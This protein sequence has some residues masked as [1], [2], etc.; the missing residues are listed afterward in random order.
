MYVPEAQGG[1]PPGTTYCTYWVHVP[2]SGVGYVPRTVAPQALTKY[3][4]NNFDPSSPEGLLSDWLAFWKVW[5]IGDIVVYG[6]VPLWARL[7]MNHAFSFVYICILSFM[8]G[9]EAVAREDGAAP[10]EVAPIEG[11]ERSLPR[12]DPKD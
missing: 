8:R 4:Q 5:V 12:R 3:Y 1:L 9:S 10:F 2:A 6:C 7:P 11:V